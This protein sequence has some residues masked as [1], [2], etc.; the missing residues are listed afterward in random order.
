[1]FRFIPRIAGVL[2]VVLA[3]TLAPAAGERPFKTSGRGYGYDGYLSA[4]SFEATHLGK[5]RFDGYVDLNTLLDSGLSVEMSGYLT[6]ANG[7]RVYLEI[8]VSYDADTGIAI[9]TATFVGGT[10]RFLDASGSAD[11]IF[12]FSLSSS[13]YSFLFE[14]DGSIAF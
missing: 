1:M 10:G 6:A 13:V 11:V 2:L 3:S 14:I 5:V 12:D 7:D 4:A 9:G 8:D